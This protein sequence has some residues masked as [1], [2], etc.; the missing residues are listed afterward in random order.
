MTALRRLGQI[1]RVLD[2]R[3][4]VSWAYDPGRHLPST[5]ERLASGFVAE[6]AALVEHCLSPEAGG[7]TPSDFP[8]A[9]LDQKKLSQLAALLGK[10]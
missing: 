8:L 6:I 5:A 1:D 2:G 9:K 10:Q 4:R 7:F 3:L